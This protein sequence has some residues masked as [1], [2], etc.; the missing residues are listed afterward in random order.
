MSGGVVR[1]Y[2]DRWFSVMGLVCLGVVVY[3][4]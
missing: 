1:G 2:V 4:V 3:F